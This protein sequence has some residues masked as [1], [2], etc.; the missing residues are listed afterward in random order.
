VNGNKR[1]L[2]N[3]SQKEWQWGTPVEVETAS[4]YLENAEAFA[5]VLRNS[6]FINLLAYTELFLI[7][8]YDVNAKGKSRKIPRNDVIKTI[9]QNLVGS[10]KK[11]LPGWEDHVLNYIQIRNCLVHNDGF[12]DDSDEQNI[13]RNNQIKKY[14][15]KTTS[16][17][18]ARMS[19]VDAGSD[20]KEY[21]KIV[22]T[23]EFFEK[24]LTTIEKFLL[25]LN[26][27][28]YQYG[29]SDKPTKSV[30]LQ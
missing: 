24:A 25:A 9:T 14:I 6:F 1:Q 5:D 3:Q 22:L 10:F 7:D 4:H 11:K 17:R 13:N 29:T 2:R 16:L 12:L 28:A 19:H 21:E 15:K 30:K 26:F 23:K 27:V 18:I 20:K 8:R